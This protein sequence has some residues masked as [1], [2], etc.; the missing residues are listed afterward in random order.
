MDK[1]TCHERGR[2]RPVDLR[3]P[4]PDD[5]WPYR[6]HPHTPH[7]KQY[8]IKDPKFERHIFIGREDI[9]YDLDAEIGMIAE[10]RK[11]PDGSEDDTLTNATTKYRPRFLRWI[12][13]HI[14]IAKG[15]METFVLEE[16]KTTK[17]NSIADVDEVDIE[18]LMP[19]W[20][21]DT[22]F[23][24]LTQAVH[25]YVVNAVMEEYL[26]LKF[27]SKDPLT[28]DKAVLAQKSLD[29]VKKFS[30]ASKPGRIRK[31]YKPF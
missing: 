31:K 15:K 30:N 8:G 5:N 26:V 27:T 14:G 9:F 22:V 13:K 6:N 28:Q 29:D 17:T 20:W 18:L 7:D 21:D 3:P 23:D 1:V 24:Q 12:D 16:F 2:Y 25:D 11:N 19:E 10:A 4:K